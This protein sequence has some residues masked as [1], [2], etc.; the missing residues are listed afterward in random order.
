MLLLLER[1]P[2]PGAANGEGGGIVDT[3][4]MHTK[5]ND[6]P[7]TTVRHQT[8]RKSGA[9]Q[10]KR[11]TPRFQQRPR[12][13]L[14]TPGTMH[15]Y[16]G[17]RALDANNGTTGSLTPDSTADAYYAHNA[18]PI[19]NV[20]QQPPCCVNKPLTEI[21][22]STPVKVNNDSVGGLHR[23]VSSPTA[24]RSPIGTNVDCQITPIPPPET[25]VAKSPSFGMIIRLRTR[26]LAPGDHQVLTSTPKNNQL[27]THGF[28]AKL[29]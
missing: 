1:L 29:P 10:W 26:R 8:H 4:R 17:V 20:L 9:D 2:K 23:S 27:L 5:Y 11:G 21:S 14:A 7:R 19:N 22:L 18:Q 25:N 6:T 24:V 3:S 13:D 28:F 15:V 16:N 12:N